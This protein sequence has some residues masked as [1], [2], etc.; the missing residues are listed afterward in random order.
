MVVVGE[1][2]LTKEAFMCPEYIFSLPTSMFSSESLSAELLSSHGRFMVRVERGV[3]LSLPGERLEVS[4]GLSL[5]AKLIKTS[6]HIPPFPKQPLA[7]YILAN[8]KTV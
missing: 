5:E 3:S 4:G 8:N 6:E 7:L 2:H 1:V